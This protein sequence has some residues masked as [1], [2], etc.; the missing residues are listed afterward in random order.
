MSASALGDVALVQ[1]DDE[2]DREGPLEFRAHV[3][4]LVPAVLLTEHL[5][6]PG[7]VPE[8]DLL[9]PLVQ[10]RHPVDE[11]LVAAEVREHL[12]FGTP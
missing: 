10:K 3:L 7:L 8:H 2:A 1:P 4:H 12:K 6:L 11:A 5:E 9:S